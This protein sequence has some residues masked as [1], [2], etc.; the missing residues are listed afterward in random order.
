[1]GSWNSAH[2]II[3]RQELLSKPSNAISFNKMLY[4]WLEYYFWAVETS[5]EV[6]QT[7]ITRL[8]IRVEGSGLFMVREHDRAWS[9]NG[10]I[11]ISIKKK[12]MAKMSLTNIYSPSVIT[13]SWSG[14]SGLESGDFPRNA[15]HAAGIHH[16][17]TSCTHWFTSKG[18]LKYLLPYFWEVKK[19]WRTWTK[20][21]WTPL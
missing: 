10:E 13:L 3:Q 5:E 9:F 16:E 12:P 8:E 4:A 2:H 11:Q 7:R 20:P 18:N 15:G 21:T 6:G 17:W 1:M 14:P 19:N